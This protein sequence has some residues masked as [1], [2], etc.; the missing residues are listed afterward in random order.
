M[1]GK[2]AMAL[3]LA[4]PELVRG[5]IVADIAPKSYPP[6]HTEILRGMKKVGA[7]EARSRKEADAVLAEHVPSKP[8]RAFLLKSLKADERGVYRWQLHVDG[9]S[10]CYDHLTAWPQIE[11][12]FE[13]PAL[14]VAGGK[15]DYVSADDIGDIQRLFPHASL[16]SIDDAGHWLHVE[17]RELFTELVTD[18]LAE[19]S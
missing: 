7:A 16:E 18:F 19:H 1:G 15:S 2:V 13:G 12:R 6:R 8:V 10:D 17:Q 14:F 9:I 11:G 4:H 3:A 5:I